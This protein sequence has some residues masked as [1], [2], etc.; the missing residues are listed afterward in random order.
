MSLSETLEKLNDLDLSE[1]DFNNMGSWPLLARVTVF[2]LVI[3]LV[4]AGG[5]WFHIKGLGEVYDREVSQEKALKEDFEKK[6]FK[7]ANLEAYKQQMVEMEET[8][9]ALLRQLPS[10]TEVAGLLEDITHT[11]L[12][13]GLKFEK[14]DL[15]PEV[16]KEFYIELPFKITVEGTYHELGSFVSGVASL[17]RIVTLHDLNIHHT[18]SET[19]KENVLAMDIL[20]RT[21][22]YNEKNTRGG[23]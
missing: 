12:G 19:V 7:V 21:Y 13:S 10:D 1:V 11:G 2:L 14:I 22:R 9:G 4:V 5:Y 20:A 3:A 16:A 18:K 15:Q 17:P 6:A 23:K 8:F